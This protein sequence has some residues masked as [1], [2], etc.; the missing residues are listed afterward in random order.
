MTTMIAI[1][2]LVEDEDGEKELEMVG[3]YNPEKPAEEM[4]DE[5]LDI[6]PA[7]EWE[8]ESIERLGSMFNGPKAFATIFEDDDP[9]IDEEL[10]SYMY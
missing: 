10:E 1:Q 3:V 2:K 8:K 5:M 7:E 9:D 4:N 6:M